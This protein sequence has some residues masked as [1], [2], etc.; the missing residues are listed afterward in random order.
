MMSGA[1][2]CGLGEAVEPLVG[3]VHGEA[4]GLEV[5][6]QELAQI[7]LVL[8]D[9]DAPLRADFRGHRGPT[10]GNGR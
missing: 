2:P 4:R 3:G 9:E 5:V 6:G 7:G 1:K 8:D 10:L